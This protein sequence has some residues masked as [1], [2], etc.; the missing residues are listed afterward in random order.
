MASIP[1]ISI[2]ESNTF[3]TQNRTEGVSQVVGQHAD[4]SYDISKADVI[5]A[6]DS[7]F[8]GVEGDTVKN[9]REFSERRKRVDQDLA[10]GV[11]S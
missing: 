1:K 7:D 3:Y 11:D 8:L 4:L 9:A 2:A 6:L 5:L 10:G